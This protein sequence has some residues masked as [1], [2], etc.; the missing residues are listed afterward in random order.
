MVTQILFLRKTLTLVNYWLILFITQRASIE[1]AVCKVIMLKGAKDAYYLYVVKSNTIVTSKTLHKRME[2]SK[3]NFA[4]KD[5]FVETMKIPNTCPTLFGL[6][7]DIEKKISTIL[8]DEN[9]PKDSAIN[10][11]PLRADATT[12]I[13]YEDMIKFIEHL[14]YLIKYIKEQIR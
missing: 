5:T 9:I 7:K 11:H 12:T 1:G 14:K 8:I 2:V 3:V 10:F 4:T 13:A 6:L